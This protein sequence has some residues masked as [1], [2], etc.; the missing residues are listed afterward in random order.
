MRPLATIDHLPEL[1][2]GEGIIDSH[3]HLDMEAFDTDRAAVLD[4]ALRA[5]VRAIVTIGAGG[6]LRCNRIALELADAHPWIFATVGIHPHEA[7]MVNEDTLGEI[8][9][10]ADHAKVVAIGETGLDYYY[11][12]SPRAKQQEAFRRFVA[13][14]REKH[15]PLVVHLREA[16]DDALRILHEERAAEVGGVIHCFSS[17]AA[18]A[19]KFLD[20]GFYLSFSG[21][22]TFRTAE[23][24]RAAARLVPTDRLMVE[25][26]AP[27]LAPEPY[28]GKRNE[29]ALVTHTAARLAEI[30]GEPLSTLARHTCENVQRL[31]GVR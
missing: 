16:D 8:A 23:E 28:R 30:R 6:P 11:D 22:L 20:L 4:R 7:S 3:C 14:A 27:F 1:A 15:L 29:P 9:R 26:D 2:D 31:L 25:T 18:A 21:I 19:R 10:L 24:I 17:N 12:H 5:R 13:L